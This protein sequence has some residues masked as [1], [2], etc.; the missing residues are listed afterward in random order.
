[1]ADDPVFPPELFGTAIGELNDDLET[2]RSCALVC[3]SF[4]SLARVSSRLQVGPRVDDEHNI[5][6]LCELLECSPSFAAGVEYLRLCDAWHGS[7]RSWIPEADLGRCLSLL[8]S[9]TRLCITISGGGLHRW[10]A[11]LH[12]PDL[13]VA[14]RASIQDTLP[15]LTTLEL[16]GIEELPL[17]LLSHCL[18]LRSLTLDSVTFSEKLNS[19]VTTDRPT[20][21][22]L[23]YL[24]LI[25]IHVDFLCRFV[26]WIMSPE[27]PGGLSCLC[28]LVCHVDDPRNHLPVLL[29]AAAPSLQRTSLRFYAPCRL[30]L[31]KL[32]NL[33]TISLET[34]C[35][36]DLSLL[37]SMVFP[38]NQQ[39]LAIVLRIT[40]ESRPKVARH[41]VDAD[42]L[43]AALPF[44]TV[45]VIVF[46][47]N[48]PT[49]DKRAEKL[50]DVADEFLPKLPLL[51]SKLGRTGAL[52]ILESIKP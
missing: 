31:H 47:W 4:Y 23:Q 42:R 3:S 36:V 37:R 30:D 45:T 29:N 10:A 51:A 13:S 14:N 50:I 28:S 16:T 2:L 21:I 44:E 26:R 12:W 15:T 11:S 49:T 32:E 48:W 27:F 17:T 8:V 20:P 1:M 38:S 52:R 39:P 35:P 24:S 33:H 18:S 43:L 34:D 19:S 40:D 7:Q 22:Q 6:Q 9:V 41:L 46:F 5:A 25:D